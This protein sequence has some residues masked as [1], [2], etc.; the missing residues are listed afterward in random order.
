MNDP[1]SLSCQARRVAC[2]LP[3]REQQMCALV[4]I[5]VKIA[6]VPMT[7]SALENLAAQYSC[8]DRSLQLPALLA[9]AEQILA[10]GIGGI[11]APDYIDYAGPPLVNPPALQNIVVDVN[12]KQ[13]Q[14]FQ[15]TWN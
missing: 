14:F 5:F 13:W 6:G 1:Q 4:A 12:G 11:G 7:C 9:L 10:K 8:V 15:N 3:S 2:W